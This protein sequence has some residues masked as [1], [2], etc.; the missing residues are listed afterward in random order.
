ME[1]LDQSGWIQTKVRVFDIGNDICRYESENTDGW[2]RKEDNATRR[3]EK[4][5]IPSPLTEGWELELKP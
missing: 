1:T 2:D 5:K 4:I 3:Q